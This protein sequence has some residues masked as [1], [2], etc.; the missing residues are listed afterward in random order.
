M[1]IRSLSDYVDTNAPSIGSWFR[2]HDQQEEV[3]IIDAN[4]V[5]YYLCSKHDH[6]QEAVDKILTWA[7]CLKTRCIW[8]FDGE[9]ILDKLP[10][11]VSRASNVECASW[12]PLGLIATLTDA[13]VI[14]GIE[15]I[16]APG[17]ADGTIAYL[18]CKY[19]A[20]ILSNDSDFY[21]YDSEGYIP[22]QYLSAESDYISGKK[23]SNKEVAQMLGISLQLLPVFAVLVGNDTF[24]GIQ[25]PTLK[26]TSKI[27]YW[28]SMLRANHQIDQSEELKTAV[29]QY[30]I[31]DAITYPFYLTEQFTLAASQGKLDPVLLKLI[32]HKIFWCRHLNEDIRKESAW[33]ASF[34]IRKKLYSFLFADDTIVTE[35]CRKG[36]QFSKT[37][38]SVDSSLK[39]SQDF[40]FKS[41]GISQESITNIPVKFRPFIAC[42]K[43]LIIYY[44]DKGLTLADFQLDSLILSAVMS[45][46]PPQSNAG[47]F[48]NTKTPS[49][50]HLKA[51]MQVL[52]FTFHIFQQSICPLNN[53]FSVKDV[54]IL[55]PRLL[56]HNLTMTRK[57]ASAEKLLR[58]VN[59]NDQMLHFNLLKEFVFR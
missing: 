44:H 11:Q 48:C 16:I 4:A 26:K 24:S 41:F 1:G 31:P 38:L 13:F 8:V 43:S 34:S 40:L 19:N 57:G 20:F 14:V 25:A 2:I 32:H 42:L 29:L 59:G 45:S 56:Y 17:E 23:I 30:K 9:S 53:P 7:S 37:T 21:I 5:C 12:I 36:T 10:T 3:W 33:D 39:F 15:Y 54:F 28:A 50:I 47:S 58:G 49:F 22:M 18:A 52:A 51:Q 6:L 46:T 35:Y 55:D 27:K